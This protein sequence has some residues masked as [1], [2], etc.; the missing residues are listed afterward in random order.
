MYGIDSIVF[1]F[2]FIFFFFINRLFA[3]D[4]FASNEQ[5]GNAAQCFSRRFVK[6][7]WR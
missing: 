4:T 3:I 1:I 5:T 2:I 7:V 6:K